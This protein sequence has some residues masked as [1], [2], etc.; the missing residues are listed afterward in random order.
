MYFL[1]YYK[2]VFTFNLD[3]TLSFHFIKVKSFY[4]FI[5][6]QFILSKVSMNLRFTLDDEGMFREIGYRELNFSGMY[7]KLSVKTAKQLLIMKI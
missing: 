6:F 7:L 2:Y 1:Y 4:H 5:A 3:F